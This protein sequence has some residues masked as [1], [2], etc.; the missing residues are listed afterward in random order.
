[1]F[2]ASSQLFQVPSSDSVWLG[3]LQGSKDSNRKVNRI[4]QAIPTFSIY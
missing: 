1:M 3:E 2:P 4:V